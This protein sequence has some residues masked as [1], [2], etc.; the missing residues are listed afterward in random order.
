MFG[1]QPESRVHKIPRP[2]AKGFDSVNS[3][4]TCTMMISFLLLSFMRIFGGGFEG[5]GTAVS[6]PRPPL[7]AVCSSDEPFLSWSFC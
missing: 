7:E 5:R 1:A 3:G 4:V 2:R 6:C